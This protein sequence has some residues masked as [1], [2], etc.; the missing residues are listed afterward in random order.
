MKER[1]RGRRSERGREGGGV[2]RGNEGKRGGAWRKEHS[3]KQKESIIFFV[4]N[5]SYPTP[6][7]S[8]TLI[9]GPLVLPVRRSVKEETNDKG[10]REN[11]Q[12]KE[13]EGEKRGLK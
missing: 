3:I 1:G 10:K 2:E 9:T 13:G 8:S 5:T 4:S 12:K 11:K 7:H 6:I